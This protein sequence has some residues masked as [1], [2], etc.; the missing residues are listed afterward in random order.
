LFLKYMGPRKWI[1]L[2]M[3]V[4]GT[5]MAVMA[6]VKNGDGL[7]ASRFFLGIAEAGL[8]PGVIF[9]LSVW[10]PRRTQTIRIALFYAAST[11]AGAFGGVLAYGIMH[12]DGMRG[13]AGWQWIFIIEALPT[14]ILAFVTFFYLPDYPENSP[15]LNNREREIVVNRIKEDAGPATETHFSWKQFFAAFLDLKVWLISIVSLCSCCPM[16]SLSLFMPTIVRD[17]GYTN[18]TAQA[19]SAIPYIFACIA[20]LTFAISS[21]R[22]AERGFHLAAVGLVGM[23]GYILLITLKDQPAAG[24]FVAATVASCGAFPLIPLISVWNANNNGGHT[25]RAVAIAIGAAVGNAGGIISGQMYRTD[26]APHYI[27]GHTISCAMM[28]A[29]WIVALI[30]R[31]YLSYENK[32]RDKLSPEQYRIACEGEDLCDKVSYIKTIYIIFLCTRRLLLYFNAVSC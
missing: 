29:N 31:M 17:L 4:W 2:I 22:R 7:L 6:T 16:Y 1:A 18:L 32:K 12:M 20:T 5:I 23:V 25:K 28:A 10:Y 30:L 24:R 27:R 13:L 21:D 15:F 11:V 9:F 3:V 8:F 19:M 14:L 26:D